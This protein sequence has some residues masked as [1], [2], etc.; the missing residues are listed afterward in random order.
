MKTAGSIH[1][2][3]NYRHA[4]TRTCK[5]K[6]KIYLGYHKNRLGGQFDF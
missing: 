2:F 6:M 3:K 5:I 1:L 4:K